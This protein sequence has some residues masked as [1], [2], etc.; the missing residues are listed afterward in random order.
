MSASRATFTPD[1]SRSES[2]V[3]ERYGARA[4]REM[5]NIEELRSALDTV[6]VSLCAPT[7]RGWVNVIAGHAKGAIK[8]QLRG[9]KGES[10]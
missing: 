10:K 2:L 8:A 4:E 7:V 9:R 5:T 1:L 3:S 6:P